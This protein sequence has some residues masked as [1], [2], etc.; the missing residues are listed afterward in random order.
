VAR[1]VAKIPVI[2][3]AEASFVL[4]RL[5]ARRFG[6]V[7]IGESDMPA[8][9]MYLSAAAPLAQ[10]VG[11]ET[12][13]MPIGEVFEDVSRTTERLLVAG[14]H[15]RDRGA[16]AIILGCMSFGFHPFADDLRTKL[17]IGVVD[18]LRASIAALQAV[19]TLQVRLG[20]APPPIEHPKELEEFLARLI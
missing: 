16:E 8:I 2:G 4:V 20:P 9:E 5:T 1:A 13:D 19:E 18:P 6:L 14:R 17:G 10:W 12:F 3:P 15:L 7:T 11:V